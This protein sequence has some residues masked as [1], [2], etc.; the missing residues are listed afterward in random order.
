MFARVALDPNVLSEDLDHDR[1]RMNAA[2]RDLARMLTQHGVVVQEG[3]DQFWHLIK[4]MPQHLQPLWS[5]A[6][7]RIYR[8]VAPP[9]SPLGV[10]HIESEADLDEHWGRKATVA[11]VERL[12][13]ALLGVPDDAAYQNTAGG[14]EVVRFD[15]VRDSATFQRLESLSGS[16]ILPGA[17][18]NRVWHDRFH[19]L[20]LNAKFLTVCDRY[21]GKELVDMRDDSGLYWLLQKVDG[22]RKTKVHIL[23]GVGQNYDLSR[24]RETFARLALDLCQG[25]IREIKLTLAPDEVFRRH[26]HNRHIRFDHHAFDIGKGTVNFSTKH[27]DQG[28]TLLRFDDKSAMSREK[29]IWESASLRE[30]VITTKGK[31]KDPASRPSLLATAPDS[32]LS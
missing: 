18:R 13:A 1:A 17:D 20:S 6:Y 8:E 19:L 12:R 4:E 9:P 7:K 29:I 24:V 15:L 22:C 5:E 23:T 31:P 30:Y 11:V 26:V 25:G 27:A 2:H 3:E 32:Q 16:Q 21:A 28:Y 10:G 14:V